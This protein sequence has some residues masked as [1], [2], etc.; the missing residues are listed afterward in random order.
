MAISRA[1]KTEKVKLLAKRAG[2]LRP[3]RDCRHFLK[4]DRS[5]DFE[6]RQG[7]PRGG[8]KYRRGQEQAGRASPGR[9]RRLRTRSKAQRCQLGGVYRGRSRGAGQG[10]CQVGRRERGGVPFQAWHCR[11]QAAGRG[12]SEGPATMPGKE[13][14]FSKLLFLISGAGAAFGY[15]A[16][17]HGPRSGSG[18]R[19]GRRERKVCRGSR[20]VKSSFSPQLSAVHVECRGGKAES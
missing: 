8:G 16:Q 2:R 15:S 4:T 5:Q 20:G 6:L 7:D 18:A 17:R 9:A 3:S 14:L 12:R 1:K 13:E 19:P 10:V 11:R